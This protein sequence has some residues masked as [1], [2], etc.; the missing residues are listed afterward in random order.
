MTGNEMRDITEDLQRALARPW[1]KLELKDVLERL[2]GLDSGSS[3]DWDFDAGEEWARVLRH[4]RAS[5]F[6]WTRGALVIAAS[7]AP[8]CS[9]VLDET[10]VLRVPDMEASC[11]AADRRTLVRFAGRKISEALDDRCFSADDLVWATI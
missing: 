8:P 2:Q 10:M 11:L 7:W 9:D 4:G 3:W 1:S 6:V 5:F